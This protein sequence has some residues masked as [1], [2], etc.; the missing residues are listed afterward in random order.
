MQASKFDKFLAVSGVLAAVLF[1]AAGFHPDPPGISA[2]AQSR[3]NWYVDH[4]TMML[5][6][7]FAGA[8][9]AIVVAFFAT[10]LRRMIRSGEAGESTYSTA[11]LAGGVLLAAGSIF[12]SVLVLS[13]VDAAD[14]ANGAALTTFAYLSD[15]SWLPLIAALA[16][17]YLATGLGGLRTATLPK[18]LS[19][20]TIVLGGAC[21]LGP[22]GVLAWFATPVWLLIMGVV[23]LR[24]GSADRA[25]APQAPATIYA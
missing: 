22:A 13:S 12:N 1:V 5:I 9:F 23:M 6:A 21:V 20:V 18:W 14:K 2:S 15:F 4:K 8:Y 17:F 24:R 25:I 7:G 16:V 11:A 10:A 19:I 3:V